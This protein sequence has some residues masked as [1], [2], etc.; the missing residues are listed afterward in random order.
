MFVV[1]IELDADLQRAAA[2][3]DLNDTV[4]YVEI[5]R[6]AK[7]T[8]EGHRRRYWNIWPRRSAISRC[9]TSGLWRRASKSK[10][11]T[12]PL[13]E[14]RLPRRGDRTEAIIALS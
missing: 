8:I 7:Q 5:Y 12:L 9:V 11:R 1:D 13:A 2:S 6:F 3:D 4:D 10:S 14:F